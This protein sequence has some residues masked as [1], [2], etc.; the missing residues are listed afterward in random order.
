MT[1]RYMLVTYIQK[2]NGLWDEVTDFK[3]SLKTKDLTHAKV[4]LDFR[5]QKVVKNGLNPEAGYDDM[6]EFYKRTIG[7]Q[8]TPYLP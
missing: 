7:D 2:P 4:I 3:N 5:E 8:L 1:K 6:L